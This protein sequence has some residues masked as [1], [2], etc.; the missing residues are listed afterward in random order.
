MPKVQGQGLLV[1]PHVILE[2]IVQNA[3]IIIIIR[4]II[5]NIQFLPPNLN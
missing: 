5:I 1:L 3:L 4:E 2:T